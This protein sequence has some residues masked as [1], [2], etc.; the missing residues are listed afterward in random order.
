MSGIRGIKR[1][2]YQIWGGVVGLF[3]YPKIW[4]E[5]VGVI[6]QKGG[7]ETRWALEKGA[8]WLLYLQN[9][10]GGYSRKFSLISGRDISYPETTG[11]LIPT[12]LRVGEELGEERFTLSALRA[13]E[14]LAG[15]QNPNGSFFEPTSGTPMVFDTGQIIYGL[16]ELYRI[17]GE[18]GYLTR[19]HR[20]GKWLLEVQEPDGSWVKYSY[21][22][23]PHTYYSRVG[24]VLALLGKV[25]GEEKFL[26]GGE[27]NIRWVLSNQLENGFFRYSSFLEG[28]P[29]YL[30]TIIYILE[31]LLEYYRLTGEKEA[32]EGAV[33]LAEGLKELNLHREILLCSQYDEEFRCLNRERCTTG[34]A[35]WAGVALTLHRL[36]YGEEYLEIATNTLYY[37]KSKLLRRGEMEGGIP[38]SIPIWGS[39]GGW[40]FVNWGN[41]FL[42]DA[43]LEYRRGE[44]SLRREEESWIKRILKITPPT[45]EEEL[46]PAVGTG[47]EMCQSGERIGVIGV[48]DGGKFLHF[49]KGQFENRE[50]NWFNFLEGE[51]ATTPVDCLILVGLFSHFSTSLPLGQILRPLK[52]GGKIVVIDR[53]KRVPKGVKFPLDSPLKPQK[54]TPA[55]ILPQL[56]RQG[57][58]LLRLHPTHPPAFLVTGTK[59]LGKGESPLEN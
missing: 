44:I 48:G 18:K 34:L 16:L 4:R 24:A 7:R 56:E 52:K 45:R 17:T 55:H 51:M 47:V 26:E 58:K 23:Q 15:I 35:Q 50:L 36:G 3:K 28:T 57:V 8:E 10:D 1:V 20:A 12:L 29:P 21:N 31:G 32:L 30:H 27:K 13:G 43:L 22:G 40:E 5:G 2:G 53:L 59:I 9:P 49:F 33:K 38:A 19:A 41:K 46:L 42:L 25:T 54:I 11:Y 6:F 14:Y 37:L 39:Y